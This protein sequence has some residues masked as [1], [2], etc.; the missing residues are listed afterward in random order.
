MRTSGSKAGE[1]VGR[2]PQARTR[3]EAVLE[4]GARKRLHVGVVKAIGLD[5]ADKFVGEV[6]AGNAFVVGGESDRDMK[7]FVDRKRV[8]VTADAK[9][10]VVAG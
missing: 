2:G 10:N 3:Q 8:F 6:D 1:H 9:D 7:F 5:G 4:A